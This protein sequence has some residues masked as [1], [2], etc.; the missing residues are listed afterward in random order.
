MNLWV[1]AELELADLQA[2]A[3]ELSD[4]QRTE[5][6]YLVNAASANGKYGDGTLKRLI[7]EIGDT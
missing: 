6:K 4:C 5:S 2:E 1:C 3:N 7:E